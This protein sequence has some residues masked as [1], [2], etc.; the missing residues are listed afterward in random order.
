VCIS[1]LPSIY[2]SLASIL[3]DSVDLVLYW[4]CA[5]RQG[6]QQIL[7]EIGLVVELMVLTM[8][9]LKEPNHHHTIM[10]TE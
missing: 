4:C 9:I 5:F 7:L 6:G 8:V 2:V 10:L 3:T 1:P